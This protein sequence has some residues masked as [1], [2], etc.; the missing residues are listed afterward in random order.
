[1]SGFDYKRAYHKFWMGFE[2]SDAKLRFFRFAFFAVFAIDAWLQIA[3]A[4]RYGASDFNVGHFPWLDAI[5]PMPT[6][7]MMVTVFGLQAYLGV[8]LAFGAVSRAAYLAQA[9]LFAFGY[10]ISQLN[11]LQHHYLLSM[12]LALIAFFPWPDL[13]GRETA[14]LTPKEAKKERENNWPVR[15]LLVSLSI[16]YFFAVITKLDS[17]WVDGSALKL[18]LSAGWMR[19]ICDA[20]GW[21]TV[22]TLTLVVELALVFL[23]H[24]R[25]LWPITLLVGI[26]MHMSFEHSGLEIGLF[27][28]F[29]LTLYILLLPEAWVARLSKVSGLFTPIRTALDKL[30]GHRVSSWLVFV[31]ALAGGVGL[32]QLLP[33]D[34]IDSLAIGIVFLAIGDFAIHRKP[35]RAGVAHIIA[36]LA[37]LPMLHMTEAVRDYYRFWGGQER[38]AGNYSAAIIAYEDLVR[39]EPSYAS[40]HR[41]LGDLYR[42]A[43]R[44]EEAIEEYEA[45]LKYAPK[46]FALN[47][48][49]AQ[50]YHIKGMGEQALRCAELATEAKS[51][52]Q[53]ARRIRD[54]WRQRLDKNAKRP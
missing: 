7:A 43:K 12:A 9:A 51:E 20:V 41:R 13:R 21:G 40:G 36:V 8:R 23:L 28:Y 44:D 45:G 16:M 2:V 14:E 39:F 54:H 52:D 10:Y 47:K 5:L 1:M 24:I 34:V 15:M 53:A 29:M 4:P 42:W 35:A 3:H 30:E 18:E 49:A 25:R 32:L 19:S 31:A 6:R 37:F 50:L 46:D 38:R 48:A 17:Q 26:V 27:S 11:S 22:A 33:F